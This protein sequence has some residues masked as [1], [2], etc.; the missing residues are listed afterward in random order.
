LIVR[1]QYV[2][3]FLLEEGNDLR[4]QIQ[5]D[6]RYEPF[7]DRATERDVLGEPLP[8]AAIEDVLRGKIWAALDSGR[9]GSKRLKDLSDIARLIEHQPRLRAAVPQELL[10]RLL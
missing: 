8:V 1:D 9:R 5:L 7:V 6:P 10:D 2:S 4:V 3:T